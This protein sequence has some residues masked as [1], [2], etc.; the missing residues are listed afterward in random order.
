MDTAMKVTRD[1]S[2]IKN[3]F[4]MSFLCRFLPAG[5]IGLQQILHI[6]WRNM[7]PNAIGV[8][9]AVV[10][11]DSGSRI[12]DALENGSERPWFRIDDR[13]F[14]P[15]LVLDRIGASHP[16]AFHDMDLSAV[17]VSSLVQPKLIGKRDDVRYQDISVPPITRIP[18]PPIRV[19]EVRP[20]VRMKDAERMVVLVNN[21]KITRT[22]KNLYRVR[23]IG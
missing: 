12:L 1:S 2:A 23:K 19:V 11:D 22:L 5:V 3:V 7:M 15:R 21:R 14:D 13:I 16:V 18:H 20:S 17:K 8:L 4:F 9:E 10:L 6:I